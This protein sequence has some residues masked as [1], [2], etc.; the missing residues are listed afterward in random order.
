MRHLPASLEMAD[1][2][3]NK[4]LLLLNVAQWRL[5]GPDLVGTKASTS[6]RETYLQVRQYYR[7]LET[8]KPSLLVPLRLRIRHSQAL[9]ATSGSACP[10]VKA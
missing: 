9:T 6:I 8:V 10:D 2:I 3:G 4:S 1:F 5:D 7:L